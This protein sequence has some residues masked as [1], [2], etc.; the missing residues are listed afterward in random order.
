MNTNSKEEQKKSTK[1]NFFPFNKKK[2]KK[3]KFK[4]NKT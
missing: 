4:I 3:M 1:E 2:R